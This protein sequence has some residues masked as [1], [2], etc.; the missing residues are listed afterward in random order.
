MGRIRQTKDSA[1]KTYKSWKVGVY[2]R[3][4][5]DDGNEVSLSIKHQKERMLEYIESHAD[6]FNLVEIYADDGFSGTDSNRENF[7][8]LLADIKSRKINCVIVKDLSRLSRNYIEAGQYIEQFFTEYDVRFISLELPALDSYK[9][10]EQMNSIIVPIQNIINDDYCR[11]VSIKIRGVFNTKRRKGEYIGGFAPYGYLRDPEDTHRFV[12]DPEASEIVKK[13]YSWYVYDGFGK[14]G[15]AKK[16][17]ELKIPNP[18]FYKNQKGINYRNSKDSD[19]LWSSAT[20]SD[21]LKNEVYLGHMVQGRYRIKSYKVKKQIR[22]PREEWFVVENT[23]EPIIDKKTF[24]LAGRLQEKD[25]RTSP[26]SEKLYIWAGLLR[27]ADCDKAM[28]RNTATGIVYYNCKTYRE[29]SKEACTKHTI[30]AD[31]LEMAVLTTIQS[32]ISLLLSMSEIIDTINSIP[33]RKIETTRIDE[34]IR[35]HIEELSKQKS[36]HDTLYLDWKNGVLSTEQYHRVKEK[37]R[38]LISRLQAA[39][40]RLNSERATIEDGKQFENPYLINFLKHENITMLD[41]NILH[42]LVNVI[43]V[44][45]GGAITIHF[46]YEDQFQLLVNYIQD[47]GYGKNLCKVLRKTK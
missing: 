46:N 25:V 20:I 24:D 35:N 28:T 40:D 4:S 11:Q 9:H 12:I 8:R 36:I 2:I 5:K 19:G 22:T 14:M 32:Q 7:Q 37:M 18:T 41:R 31:K 29:K 38:V 10:P 16:L 39:I 34:Q 1:G 42:E 44:H 23:H 3:L 43:Y 47:N 33:E 6:E 45:E 13:I 30:R 26:K 21:I 27:C 17:N 15:I